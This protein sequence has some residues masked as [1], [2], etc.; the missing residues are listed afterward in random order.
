MPWWRAGKTGI[1]SKF[2]GILT[3]FNGVLT[4]FKRCFQEVP[5]VPEEIEPNRHATLFLYLNEG[6]TGG[7]TVFPYAKGVTKYSNCY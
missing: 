2:N 7:E 6:F 1:K 3:A 5:E 4:V